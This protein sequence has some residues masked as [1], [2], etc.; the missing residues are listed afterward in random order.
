MQF[1]SKREK[2]STIPT[3]LQFFCTFILEEGEFQAGE[4]VKV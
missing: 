2:D 3:A 1:E 4:W